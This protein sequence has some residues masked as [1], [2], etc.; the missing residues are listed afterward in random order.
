MS[1]RDE[2]GRAVRPGLALLL[3][4]LAMPATAAVYKW[5][6][7]DGKVHY[8]DEPPPDAATEKPDTDAQVLEMEQDGGDDEASA[9]SDGASAAPQQGRVGIATG[10]AIAPRRI[11]TNHHVVDGAD[12]VE[13]VLGEDRRVPARVAE[14]DPKHDLALLRL[15][16]DG[17]RLDPIP[18]QT[19]PALS[20]T[21]VL[22]IGYPHIDVMGSEP[23][24]T[25]GVIS[26]TSGV[27]DDERLY[28]IQTPIQ[29]GNS[30]GPLFNNKGQVVGVIVGKLNAAAVARA[31]G[32]LPQNVNYAVKS[33]FLAP[34]LDG[35]NVALDEGEPVATRKLV[36]QVRHSVV[37]VMVR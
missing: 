29:K 13:I 24:V 10:W 8:S 14:T 22:T 18:V 35:G 33:Q 34:W 19:K 20:G 37:M 30:G 9:D 15:A 28:Q 31:S 17:T 23:K 25:Q 21:E 26:A 12:S 2:E 3:A 6:D 32:D 16:D 36:Q 27:R 4:A 7:D 11:V 1:P 5:T